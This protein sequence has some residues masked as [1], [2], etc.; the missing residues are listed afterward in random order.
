LY[1]DCFTSILELSPSGFITFNSQGIMSSNNDVVLRMLN[2]TKEELVGISSQSLEQEL[3]KKCLHKIRHNGHI[4]TSL[5]I[6]MDETPLIIKRLIRAILT[7][8]IA[9]EIHYFYDITHETNVSEMKTAL[10]FTAAHELR[11]SM[12]SIHGYAELL[13]KRA[14]REDSQSKEFLQIILKQSTRLNNMI[15]DILDLGRSEREN[16][17]E[18]STEKLEVNSFVNSIAEEF[19]AETKAEIHP[20]KQSIFIDADKEKL[21]RAIINILSNSKKYSDE[22]SPI[23][24][25]INLDDDSHMVGIQVADKGIGMTPVQQSQLFTRFYR[26][27]PEGNIAG[28]GLGLCFVKEIL[29][30]H[31]GGVEVQSQKG[32][33]TQ[34]TLWIPTVDNSKFH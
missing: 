23:S 27:N 13:L 18:L 6:T 5:L 9:S 34:V 10:L 3:N 1:R 11:N 15:N 7:Q 31:C 33:G 8:G 30:L 29:E 20:F 14:A 17:L 16:I 22:G 4:D 28:T 21:S 19:F 2:F 25:T 12:S 24:I 32:E 26:A